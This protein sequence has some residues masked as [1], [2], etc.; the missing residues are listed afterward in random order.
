MSRPW[1]WSDKGDAVTRSI[2]TSPPG[3]H[4]GCGVLLR[5]RCGRV[6]M[7]E[8]DPDNPF[9]HGRLCPR[10]L[11]VPEALAD[12]ARL[13]TPLKRSGPRGSNSWAAIG[14]EEAL[15]E[16]SAILGEAAASGGPGSVA[17]CKGTG[18]DIGPWL[19]TLAFGFG[20]PNYFAF[21]PGTGA[22]CLMPRM[23]AANAVLGDWLVADCS[24]FSPLR[25]DDPGWRVPGCILVWGSNPV[26]SNP[27]GFLG[28]WIARCMELG[29]RLVVV[30]PRKTWLAARAAVHLQIRPGTDGA[31]ALAMIRRIVSSGGV[32][33]EFTGRWVLGLEALADRV[34]SWTAGEAE[35]V[36]G[37]PGSLI[38]R[39][40]DL[41]GSSKPSAMH[42]GVSVDMSGSAVGTAMALLALSAITG[43]IERP[44]GSVIVRDPCGIPRRGAAPR[45][46]EKAL[47]E[48]R[49]PLIRLAS[50]YAHSDALLEE[51]ERGPGSGVTAAWIQ[52]TNTFVSSFAS[53][54]RALDL[55]GRMRGVVVVD[56]FLTPTAAALADIVMPPAMYPE[57]DGLRNWWYQLATVNRAVDPPG[58]MLSDMEIILETGRRVAPGAFPWESV[59]G[60][61]DSILAPSGHTFESLREAGWLMPG[62][63]YGRHERGMLR[64]DGEPGFRTPSGRI[65]LESSVMKGFGLDPLPWYAEPAVGPVSRP[66]LTS[67]YPLVLT[68]GARTTVFF[69]SENRTVPM[70]RERNPRP[71]V[72]MHSS[73]ALR[74]GVA[75]GERVR[76]E[77]PWGSC[78]LFVRVDDSLR[79][80]TVHAQ[81]GWWLPE[82]QAAAGGQA[83]SFLSM[84]VN[85]LFPEGLQAPDGM[86]YPFRSLL[87]RI[88]RA[89]GAPRLP[90]P[91]LP[92]QGGMLPPPAGLRVRPEICC[93]CR[94]CEIACLVA[95]GR[96]SGTAGIEISR[97]GPGRFAPSWTAVCDSCSSRGGAWFCR[98]NCPTGCLS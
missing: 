85:V 18:R 59:R 31:L 72:E 58:G 67:D 38:E 3:C 8:G 83:P 62:I 41:F 36:C 50:P 55:L 79:P 52:G 43:N 17:F 14:W 84:N 53:P 46:R 26:W 75:E 68:T 39:A 24:Q 19:S 61:I 11:A 78:D 64:E 1:Q 32:D 91:S 94:A 6:T 49:W 69:H 51:L 56:P 63:E 33:R 5:S 25:Y 57:R 12:P 48:E 22:A 82:E 9:S 4:G 81:H 44:G 13:M 21:G 23:A 95:S 35:A 34:E 88:V 27:D 28:A 7:A 98:A 47:G 70:L 66:D 37:I 15:E 80:D 97:T 16:A 45:P 90:E 76:L 74:A 30:D 65:E 86:G 29:S 77:S 93:G 73:A 40:A 92:E 60:W 42:W 20:S 87:C 96:K 10:G 2:C 71:L 54:G 89:D